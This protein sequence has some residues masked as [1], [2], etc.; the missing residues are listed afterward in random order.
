MHVLV[1]P[2]LVWLVIRFVSSCH[3]RKHLF[4]C[5]CVIAW[6][7][8]HQLI[9][10]HPIS[11]H[12]AHLEIVLGEI[13]CAFWVPTVLRSCTII[14]SRHRTA[15]MMLAGQA[16]C[17]SPS[18]RRG[19]DAEAAGRGLMPRPSEPWPSRPTRQHP[20]DGRRAHRAPGLC[21]K[22]CYTLLSPASAE[23]RQ[24]QRQGQGRRGWFITS[25]QHLVGG[26]S[27][28]L[29]G[30]AA[31]ERALH[32]P[33]G[34]VMCPML[35]VSAWPSMALTASVSAS[36]R[37]GHRPVGARRRGACGVWARAARG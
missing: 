23:H 18:Q 29:S 30:D 33:A 35:H 21:R 31:L 24:C 16:T 17:S 36:A 9:N 12:L 22:G 10:A 6:R 20:D 32:A 25:L 1:S 4:F 19:Q 37:C 26:G 3:R 15:G 7:T 5:C 34:I 27:A 8:C 14:L 2:P 28:T 11:P 13:C